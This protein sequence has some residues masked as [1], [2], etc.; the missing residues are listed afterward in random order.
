MNRISYSRING[1]DSPQVYDRLDDRH[2]MH[3]FQQMFTRAEV[4]RLNRATVINNLPHSVVNAIEIGGR[5]DAKIM[6]YLQGRRVADVIGVLPDDV[7]G[8]LE[9]Q[10]RCNT[11][12]REYF[13][14]LSFEELESLLPGEY[15]AHVRSDVEIKKYLQ[16][17]R[18]DQL[19]A[20][21]PDR[22]Q[23]DMA[24]MEQD[25]FGLVTRNQELDDKLR[26]LNSQPSVEEVNSIMMN[27]TMHHEPDEL[28][29][30][31]PDLL[32]DH[33]FYHV[34][35]QKDPDEF[36]PF[37]EVKSDHISGDIADE[38]IE[39]HYVDMSQIRWLEGVGD[40]MQLD[41]NG[42]CDLDGHDVEVPR[43]G[44]NLES[45]ETEEIL[46]ILPDHVINHFEDQMIVKMKLQDEMYQAQL[47]DMSR[48]PELLVG[49]D[50]SAV[51]ELLPDQVKQYYQDPVMIKKLMVRMDVPV[52]LDLL[53]ESVKQYYQDPMRVKEILSQLEIP[54][55]MDLLPEHV[56]S[57]INDP[58]RVIQILAGEPVSRI[59]TLLPEH[60]QAYFASPEHLVETLSRHSP[61]QLV[62]YMPPTIVA[63]PAKAITESIKHRINCLTTLLHYHGHFTGLASTALFLLNPTDY[64]QDVFHLHYRG[65]MTRTDLRGKMNRFN[66]FRVNIRNRENGYV[67]AF[68]GPDNFTWDIQMVPRM[69][70]QP[71]NMVHSLS[72]L[73]VYKDRVGF[74]IRWGCTQPDQ[75]HQL[76][77]DMWLRRG[78]VFHGARWQSHFEAF[79]QTGVMTMLNGKPFF[80]QAN[81]DDECPICLDNINGTVINCMTCNI[82]IHAPCFRDNMERLADNREMQRLCPVCNS[83]SGL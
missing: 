51:L 56:Q 10:G 13:A 37:L 44:I 52:I 39:Q 23:Q 5:S 69:G 17:Y 64:N 67:V 78:R 66:N 71:P 47:M 19:R 75:L 57:Y 55:V 36:L 27:A 16:R 2:K 12:L 77:E 79:E 65:N 31:V 60:Y 14:A 26:R 29:G 9:A 48:I 61:D 41:G 32:K 38:I 11:K 80:S 35:G 4:S 6:T 7:I 54:V 28:M 25:L 58:V 68:A 34:L 82:K 62:Q 45:M 15:L 43:P 49:M 46:A 70:Q 1:H 76:T 21:L 18:M 33:I 20:V 42:M 50:V 8:A 30:C 72:S 22:L 24:Q 40:V 63:K 81:G 73:M 83:P 3:I 53:P 74:M 59:T